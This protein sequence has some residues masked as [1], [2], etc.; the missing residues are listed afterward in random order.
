MNS[1]RPCLL[2]LMSLPMPFPALKVPCQLLPSISMP[3]TQIARRRWRGSMQPVSLW[4][5]A[6]AV[7]LPA[8]QCLEVMPINCNKHIHKNMFL[9]CPNQTW[10]MICICATVQ[11]S[12]WFYHNSR[13]RTVI[14][15]TI[16]TRLKIL[17]SPKNEILEKQ[18]D[19][20][21]YWRDYIY[22]KVFQ[23][24]PSN[25]F[26]INMEKHKTKPPSLAFR[27]SLAKLYFL[28]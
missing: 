21:K 25:F 12:C 20:T 23:H 19:K 11:F 13:R 18:I 15:P 2:S 28:P 3:K 14:H 8:F 16:T 22:T 10:L 24:F 5:S 1:C 7:L 9:A 17:E 27:C 6:L 4:L 26:S